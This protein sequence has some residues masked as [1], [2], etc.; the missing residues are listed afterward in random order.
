MTQI[1]ATSATTAATTTSVGAFDPLASLRATITQTLLA[2][3]PGFKLIDERVAR[4]DARLSVFG[5][6]ALA[7]DD[8]RTVAAGLNPDA[9]AEGDMQT[10]V[11]R[12][13][14]A[15]VKRFVDAFNTLNGKLGQLTSG[16]AESSQIVT[17]MQSQIG[18]VIGHADSKALAAL[19]ITRKDGALVLDEG[20]LKAAL[21]ADPKAA[22]GLFGGKDGLA[23]RMT[24]QVGRQIGATG[25]LGNEAED[26]M[27]TRDAL[28][29]QQ[30]KMTQIIDR[31]AT[32][33]LQQYQT[34]G[35]GGSLLFGG[36]GSL[37]RPPSL[38][39]FMA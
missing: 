38:F 5:K 30:K 14:A 21:E 26:A 29:A 39:D 35:A 31:Q 22:T 17:R 16:D 11:I 20:K 2:Q 24:A 1:T 37:G 27:N 15:D 13:P 18:A 32:L 19:G 10:Q 9:K 7:L 36:A 25:S 3:N 12:E 34:A 28:L 23:E 6:L 8:F 4:E 33:M